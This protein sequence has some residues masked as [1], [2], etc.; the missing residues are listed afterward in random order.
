MSPNKPPPTDSGL[1]R[2]VQGLT[3]L[4]VVIFGFG[5]P[6]IY[7]LNQVAAEEGIPIFAYV[8]WQCFGA[9]IILLA[10]IVAR[11]KR[12][13]LGLKYLKIYFIT[14]L[15][16]NAIPLTAIAYATRHVPVGVLTLELTLEPAF[17]YL[18]ALML[19]LE[20]FHWV[21]FAGLAVG[22][23]GLMLIVV[24]EASLPSPHMV[25][26]VIL[27]L[28]APIGWALLSAWI[29]RARPPEVD[30]L[31]LACASVL[32]AALFLLPAMALSGEWWW[33][34]A[35]LDRGD[36]AVFGAAFANALLWF[37]AFECIRL[38]GP[39]VYS[40]WAYVGTPVGIGF[41]MWFFGESHSAWIWGALVL[42]FIGLFLVNKT[43]A[44]A[45]IAVR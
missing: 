25:P 29:A 20:K 23:A 8:F 43:T 24:P 34:E 22:M 28:A 16:A 17:T 42:L 4:L 10:V 40:T 6:T 12:P 27:G 11:R 19:L 2:R 31:Y 45:R 21:R 7:A 33:V 5:W 14:G 1:H 26:W 35:P 38:A 44:K 30:S 41:G 15:L 9:G 39:V 3:L 13:P 37:L 36:F 32:P 18:F